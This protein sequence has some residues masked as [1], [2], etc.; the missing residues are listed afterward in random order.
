MTN[1][2]SQILGA[3]N[4]AI[5]NWGTW[6]QQSTSIC[7]GQSQV[8]L[9]GGGGRNE[10]SVNND[11]GSKYGKWWTMWLHHQYF[12]PPPDPCETCHYL[13]SLLYSPYLLS[14][15]GKKNP[16]RIHT[17]HKSPF[18]PPPPNFVND[19]LDLDLISGTFGALTEGLD[20]VFR[21]DSGKSIF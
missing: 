10:Y 9:G 13:L 14:Q 11:K 4:R 8:N 16:F 6:G 2:I 20:R 7:V 5:H 21:Q 19:T 17:V 12:T 15:C 18:Y 3:L 1:H